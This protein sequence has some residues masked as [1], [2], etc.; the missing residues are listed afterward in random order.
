MKSQ[1][2]VQQRTGVKNWNASTKGTPR[3][4]RCLQLLGALFVLLAGAGTH[5]VWAQSPEKTRPAE[6]FA[7][8][9]A[10]LPSK[11][12]NHRITTSPERS[13][14]N[15]DGP[16]A[17]AR[18]VFGRLDLPTGNRPI[19]VAIGAFQTGGPPSLAVTNALA[20]TVSVLLGN[21]DGTFQSHVDYPTGYRSFAVIAADFNGDG[22]LDLATADASSDAVSI[23]LGN[24]DGT[25]QSAVN[26]SAGTY[27]TGLVAGDFNHDGH[28]DLAA[29]DYEGNTV[30]V[31]LGN[32]DGTFQAP[33]TYPTG[34]TPYNVVTADFNADGKLDLAVVNAD[35]ETISVLLGN[36]DGTFREPLLRERHQAAMDSRSTTHRPNPRFRT[37]S[38]TPEVG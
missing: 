19:G 17:A 13:S 33:V 37:V 4:Q 34:N 22:K 21:P 10:A 29:A 1:R 9:S 5:S 14:A 20:G 11:V 12:H 16:V 25:F 30:A 7:P 31:L 26:Y 2:D 18:Y 15:P 32:G 3:I 38:P 28:L 24:G 6:M 23:L 27:P 36:G 35:S 8:K